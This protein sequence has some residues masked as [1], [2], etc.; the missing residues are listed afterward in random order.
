M[1]GCSLGSCSVLIQRCPWLSGALGTCAGSHSLCSP[2]ASAPTWAHPHL[3]PA[4]QSPPSICIS[5]PLAHMSAS[6]SSDYPADSSALLCP[7]TRQGQAGAGRQGCSH[8]TPVKAV[9]AAPA[10]PGAKQDGCSPSTAFPV[11]IPQPTTA[12]DKS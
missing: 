5:H 6:N 4:P 10:T 8:S 1:H 2:P 3:S 11:P 7:W 9:A 12:W